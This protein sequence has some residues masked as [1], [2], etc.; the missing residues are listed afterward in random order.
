[1]LSKCANAVQI[2]GFFLIYLHVLE[3]SRIC[4]KQRKNVRSSEDNFILLADKQA[5]AECCRIAS[6]CILSC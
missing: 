4:T 6:E 3:V 1:M 5:F 2:W